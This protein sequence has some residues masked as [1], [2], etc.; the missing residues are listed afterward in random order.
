MQLLAICCGGW[1]YGLWPTKPL[2]K[3]SWDS[4]HYV[5]SNLLLV[6][7]FPGWSRPRTLGQETVVSKG[8]LQTIDPSTPPSQSSLPYPPQV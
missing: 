5:W 7:V 6:L 8:Y 2:S 3:G 1:R 4:H